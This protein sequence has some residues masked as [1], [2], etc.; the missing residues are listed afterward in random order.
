MCH[1]CVPSGMKSQVWSSPFKYH[2]L[3]ESSKYH[4]HNEFVC[5]LVG[6]WQGGNKDRHDHASPFWR[7]CVTSMCCNVFLSVC[8]FVCCVCCGVCCTM[9]LASASLLLWE[10]SS[11]KQGCVSISLHLLSQFRFHTIHAH[12]RTDTYIHIYTHMT[13]NTFRTSFKENKEIHHMCWWNEI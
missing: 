8:C 9:G 4:K 11:C 13:K 3:N 5:H 7:I 10:I 2:Q 12:A 6:V 1:V